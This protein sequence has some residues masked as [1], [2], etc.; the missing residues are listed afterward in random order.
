MNV[1]A[2]VTVLVLLVGG[3]AAQKDDYTPS[4]PT[5]VGKTDRPQLV[6]FYHPL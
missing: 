3:V 4:D 6:E 5:R 1:K 2:I